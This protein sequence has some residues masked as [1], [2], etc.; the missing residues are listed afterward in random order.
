MVTFDEA[1]ELFEENKAIMSASAIFFFISRV[2][3]AI[4]NVT[5]G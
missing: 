1:Y 4:L 5:H 3:K 2:Y